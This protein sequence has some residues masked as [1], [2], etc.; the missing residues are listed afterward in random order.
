MI[1]VSLLC[2]YEPIMKFLLPTVRL[3]CT[4]FWKLAFGT[5]GAPKKL[6]AVPSTLTNP[7]HPMI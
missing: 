7:A 5:D 4:D 3:F 1:Y 6:Y 2:T